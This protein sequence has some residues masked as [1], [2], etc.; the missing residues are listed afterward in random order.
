M[1]RVFPRLSSRWFWIGFA[2]VVLLASIGP[3]FAHA[4]IVRSDP[5]ANAVLPST[6]GEIRLWFTEPLEPAF[7]K[8]ILRDATGNVLEMPPSQVD[9]N[10]SLQMSLTPTELPE[11]VYTI[12]WRAL[13]QADGH[14]SLGSFPIV[15]GDAV[16]GL[17]SVTSSGE[18]I[19]PESAAVRFANLLSLALGVGGL[20][21]LLFVWTPTIPEA[22][23]ALEQRLIRVVW[24]GWSLIGITGLLIVLMQL[25]LATGSPLLVD[26]NGD[27]LNALVTNTR[28]GHLWLLR[29]ALWGGMGGALWFAY[30]DRW[31]IWVAMLLGGSLLVVQSAF[32]HANGAYDMNAAVAA[33]WLHLTAMVAWVGGLVQFVGIIGPVRGAFTPASLTLSRLVAHFTNF[34]RIAVAILFLTGLYSAWL[35][36][37]SVDGLMNTPYGQVL[38]VKLILIVPT[39]ALAAINM[40]YTH[41]GLAAG[42]EIWGSRLRRLIG[43]EIALTLGVLV[44]VGM[45]T[46]ASPAR[47]TLAQRAA[48][49]P[50]P[51]PQPIV[52]SQ[53]A[54]DLAMELSIAPGWVGENTFTLKLTSGG[55]PV[56]N[57]TLIRMRFE[58][59]TANLGESELRPALLGDGLYAISAANL[60]A[61]GEWRVRV[62]VQRPDQYDALADF[63]PDVPAMPDPIVPVTLPDPSD[64]LPNRT[65]M[66]ILTGIGALTIGGFFFGENR[67]RPVR[68][69]TLLAIGLLLLGGLLLLA[70]MQPAQ[71]VRITAAESI[72]NPV[73]A[74]AVATPVPKRDARMFGGNSETALTIIN[75]Q[76]QILQQ[77]ADGLWRVLSLNTAA[78]DVYVDTNGV[79]WAATSAGLYRSTDTDWTLVDNLPVTR[80]DL[81]HGYLFAL[82]KGHIAQAPAGGGSLETPRRLDTP[83]PDQDVV[84]IAMLDDHSHVILSGG[85]LFLT[86]DIGLNWEPIAAPNDLPIQMIAVDARGNLLA[87]T[88]D[89]LYTWVYSSRTWNSPVALPDNDSSPTI[90][91]LNNE[92]YAVAGGRLLRFLG[93][94]WLPLRLP[95]GDSVFLT[96]LAIQYPQ[97]LWAIDSG[98]NALWS[99]SDGIHW[100]RQ[101]LELAPK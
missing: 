36:V 21:F 10:D 55:Q 87:T 81:M 80:L 95:E 86:T 46:A 20:A 11:G 84:E 98:S 4:N 15:I 32:S 33:D 17:S 97:T 76:G 69:S 79:T 3:V 51:Q 37:G 25:A 66:L 93:L 44:T 5:P 74:A 82:G 58:S 88:R 7:S 68:L 22:Q 34:A 62:T 53:S 14:P 29:M 38:L 70:A 45:M 24:V 27:T 9:P 42:A 18:A 63:T 67:P 13:S 50:P 43:A 61:M 57:A 41:R 47:T 8:I 101:A 91:V 19:P 60:S 64:P 99:S 78:N 89:A 39:L 85:Q 72:P 92:I 73:T 28:F 26:I 96:G 65:I 54:N 23:P 71:E 83:L 35:Q 56:N 31:F 75:G 49:P 16:S 12:A 48:N 52:I 2:V 59:Q 6:P 30:E 100:T 90:K 94:Q 40:L 77:G 1:R